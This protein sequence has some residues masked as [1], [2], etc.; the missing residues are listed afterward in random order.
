MVITR[1]FLSQCGSNGWYNPLQ[2]KILGIT[3]PPL[4]DWKKRVLGKVISNED[5]KQIKKYKGMSIEQCIK[6]NQTKRRKEKKIECKN[7]IFSDDLLFEIKNIVRENPINMEGLRYLDSMIILL[8]NDINLTKEQINKIKHL[9]R[10]HKDREMISIEES[11]V[12]LAKDNR[13][14]LFKIGYSKNPKSRIN[15][16]KTANLNIELIAY[17]HGSYETEKRL[18]EKFSAYRVDREWF[19]L[20]AYSNDIKKEFVD[21]VKQSNQQNEEFVKYKEHFYNKHNL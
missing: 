18:H 10:T 8:Q 13:S 16:L 6:F 12:Y 7:I 5:A 4:D 9:K 19:N 21:I 14:N 11:Y 3:Y 17:S 15:S 2:L 20:Y 1:K